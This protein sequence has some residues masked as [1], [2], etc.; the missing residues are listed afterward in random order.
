MKNSK[1]KK[2][3]LS[4]R[5]NHGTA[6]LLAVLVI[7]ILVVI[8]VSLSLIMTAELGL[9]SDL[10]KSSMAYY[11]AEA[12]A[13]AALLKLKNGGIDS[14]GDSGEICLYSNVCYRFIGDGANKKI[15][16]LG[17]AF[18]VLRKLEI[19][20]VPDIVITKIA[21]GNDHSLALASNGTVWVTGDNTEDQLGLG[22][23]RNSR[24]SWE[25]AKKSSDT[26]LTGIINL[27]GGGLHSLAL[28]GSNGSVWATGKN[29]DG[30][31]GLEDDNPDRD[32]WNNT[33]RFSG[34]VTIIDVTAIMGGYRHS[35]ALKPD[36]VWAAGWNMFGQLGLKSAAEG[37]FDAK[38]VWTKTSPAG[39]IFTSIAAGSGYAHSLALDS[40]SKVWATGGGMYGQLGSGSTPGRNFPWTA[41]SPLGKTFSV[42]ASGWYHSLA[43]ESSD[44]K[45]VW[46]TGDNEYGQL[47]IG[48][49]S[50]ACGG[51]P[52]PCESSWTS[53][54]LTDVT[55][56]AAG[57]GHSLALKSDGTVWA[58]GRNNEGQLGLG[59]S[60]SSINSWQQAKTGADTYLTR[61]V[62][63]AAGTNHSL[64]LDSKGAVWVTGANNYGQLG[65][66]SDSANNY[67]YFTK[68]KF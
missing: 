33:T 36:G 50:G 26:Y 52:T 34:I 22:V 49:G 19:N 63:I 28:D 17:K 16:S 15:T 48:R 66:G 67:Y 55:A 7:T 45:R 27:A 20:L 1:K 57:N 31:L 39:T 23:D 61:I 10:K 29:S 51:F 25:Q 3:L 40:S 64:A 6:L 13:E 56:I 2:F 43:V 53:T 30:Q 46:A 12:G 59:A 14:V 54:S 44:N 5:E 37:G 32:Y 38:S 24:K 41:T 18:G 11:S 58:A 62:A 35:L 21:A 65:L 8:T 4:V 47:G 42:I 60:V 9:S 68:V